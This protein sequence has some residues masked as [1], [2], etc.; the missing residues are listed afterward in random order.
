MLVMEYVPNGDLY[1]LLEH[2]GRIKEE[3]AKKFFT[4]LL[5]GL[6]YCH[7]NNVAHRDIKPENILLD[8]GNNIKIADFGLSNLMEAGVFFRTACGSPDYAA[9]EVISGMRYAGPAVDVWSSGILL[10]AL[11]SATLPFDEPNIPSLFNRIRNAK[12]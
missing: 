1:S 2:R 10:Y 8:R 4:Q 9:P 5:E 12:Y 11:V 3:E 6:D 7:S